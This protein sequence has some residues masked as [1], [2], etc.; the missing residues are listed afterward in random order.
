MPPSVLSEGQEVTV[1]CAEGDT[2]LIYA[3]LLDVEVTDVA[4]DKCPNH[5]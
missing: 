5:R 4:L 2:G 1:S 3:G